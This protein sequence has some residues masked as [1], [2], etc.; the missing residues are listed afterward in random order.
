MTRLRPSTI[1]IALVMLFYVGLGV[2]QF[3]SGD[4]QRNWRALLRSDVHGYHGYLRSVFILH[5]LGHEPYKKEYTQIT[6]DGTLNKC[7]AGESVMMVPFFL[8]AH[9]WAAATG[10][11]T[12][13]LSKP[14]MAAIA[15]AGLVYVLLGLLALR[16]L[17]SALGASDRSIAWVIGALGFGTQLALYTGFQ[18]G[19]T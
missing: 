5:D 1:I 15:I 14:Y 2:M 7:W 12:D 3:T 9:A 13:G 8:A 4:D 6:P 11:P 10:E 18:P 16:A 19:W 17:L